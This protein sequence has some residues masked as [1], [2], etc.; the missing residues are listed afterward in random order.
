MRTLRAVRLTTEAARRLRDGCGTGRV[1]SAF[2]HTVNVKLDEAGDAAWVSLHAPGPIPAP[3]GI[4]CE[5]WTVWRLPAGVPVRVEASAIVLDGRLRVTLDGA[6]I[7]D[8]RLPALAPL[9]AVSGC[10]RDALSGVSAGLLPAAAALLTGDPPP[11]DPISRAAWPALVRLCVAT[12]SRSAPECL[13]AAHSLLG[14]GPGL[15]PAGDDC[16]VGWLAGARIAGEDGRELATAVAP[17]LLVAATDRTTPLSRAFLA[18]AAAGEAAEPVHGF[19]LVP[20]TV[21]LAGLLR[22]GATSGADLL[23]GY[24]LARVAL[25]PSAGEG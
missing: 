20:D 4:A 2:A 7:S 12:H 11:T 1:H 9:P 18:A 14:L 8:T 10:L 6:A 16:L 15:T 19:A 13:A 3:F 21:R 24:L 25:A 5:T 22:L 17:G 23:A